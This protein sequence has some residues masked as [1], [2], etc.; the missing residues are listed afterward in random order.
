MAI[1]KIISMRIIGWRAEKT[2]TSGLAKTGQWYL[3]NEWWWFPLR[4]K[5]YPGERIGLVKVG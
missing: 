4:E 1:S 5:V 3:D 2:F